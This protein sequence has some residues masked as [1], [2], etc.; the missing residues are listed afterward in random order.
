MTSKY[1][2][3]LLPS[4]YLDQAF[5]WPLAGILPSVTTPGLFTVCQLNGP[6]AI[7]DASLPSSRYR[8]KKTKMKCRQGA[9]KGM[10]SGHFEGSQ[11]RHGGAT[12]AQGG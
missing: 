4:L 3:F 9:G 8:K 10:A 2:P 6:T 1:L 12:C 5:A 11:R 7:R